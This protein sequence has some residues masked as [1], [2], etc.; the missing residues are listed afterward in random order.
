[1]KS[2]TKQY[3]LNRSMTTTTSIVVL[4]WQATNF[5]EEKKIFS[6]LTKQNKRPYTHTQ[7][8]TLYTNYGGR[9]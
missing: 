7:T 8:H 2:T 6:R 4:L 9:Q 1:M 5:I 3:T